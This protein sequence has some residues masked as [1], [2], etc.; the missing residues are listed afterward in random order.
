MKLGMAMHDTLEA[1]GYFFVVAS[2]SCFAE[3]WLVYAVTQGLPDPLAKGT[4]AGIKLKL[5]K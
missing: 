1:P 2:S 3:R 5:K 4:P